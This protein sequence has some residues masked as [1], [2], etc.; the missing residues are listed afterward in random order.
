MGLARVHNIREEVN[1]EMDTIIMDRYC[2][3][4]SNFPVIKEPRWHD[5]TILIN[6]NV[7]IHNKVVCIYEKADGTRMFPEPLYVSGRIAKKFRPFNMDTM[8]GGTV[9]IRAVPIDEF[10]ILKISDKSLHEAW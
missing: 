10:K 9:K 4:K 5:N 7:G 3:F 1:V 6:A 2:Q 8:A